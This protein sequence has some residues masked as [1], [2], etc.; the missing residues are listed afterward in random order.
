MQ[1][2]L[3]MCLSKK[4]YKTGLASHLLN[5]LK[6]RNESIFGNPLMSSALYLDPRFHMVITSNQDKT[7]I[8]TQ[9]ILKIGRRLEF[10]RCQGQNE[11]W[12]QNAN[13]SDE[14]LSFEFDEDGAMAG[15]QN[16]SAPGPQTSTSSRIIDIEFIESFQPDPMPVGTSILEYWES[17]KED[18][19]A[20]Y[21]IAMAIH[22]VPPTEVQIERDF[23][24][25][26][27]IFSDRRTA[28]THVR[29]ED[30]MLNFL[31]KELYH[32]VSELQLKTEYEKHEITME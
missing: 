4:A 14:N 27:F 12:I 30:I 10:L 1:L 6:T 19:F 20:L 8:A 3:N 16:Q 9:N 7:K 29:L 23:S 5:A 22:S 18:N 24:S 26:G 32:T 25:L 21:Q 2:H 15:H 11:S 31:N 17:K 13:N 28:L